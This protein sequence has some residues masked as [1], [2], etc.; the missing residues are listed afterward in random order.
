MASE[1]DIER[2]L[3]EKLREL[4]YTYRPD[5]R[6]RESLER[7][8]REK[9]EELNKV[10]LTDSEFERSLARIVDPDVFA[11]ARRLREQDNFERED[12]APLK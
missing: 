10:H 7:N 8:F 1:S 11:S 9:F 6:D 4:K 3:I 5:I 12:G 2:A